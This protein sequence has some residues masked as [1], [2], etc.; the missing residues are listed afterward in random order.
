[1]G[2]Y[3]PNHRRHCHCWYGCSCLTLDSDA[4]F[5]SKP[6]GFVGLLVLSSFAPAPPASLGC[7]SWVDVLLQDKAVELELLRP[8]TFLGIAHSLSWFALK[9]GFSTAKR[10][11]ESM[12]M[13][14]TASPCI[15]FVAWLLVPSFEPLV[16]VSRYTVFSSAAVFSKQPFIFASGGHVKGLMGGE[17]SALSPPVHDFCENYWLARDV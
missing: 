10:L 4:S 15:G 16:S 9:T 3:C 8:S 17:L 11:V 1:M 14:Y 12:G 13:L 6:S 7:S 5:I 2:C